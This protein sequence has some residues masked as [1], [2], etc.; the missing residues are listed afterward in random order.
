MRHYTAVPEKYA[1]LDFVDVDLMT[2]NSVG[3]K[4]TKSVKVLLNSLSSDSGKIDPDLEKALYHESMKKNK[5]FRESQNPSDDKYLSA[6]R[7]RHSFAITCHK[8]QGGEW[9]N[10][11]IHPWMAYNDMRWLYTAVTRAKKTVYSY[12]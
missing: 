2:T 9:N 7:L 8:A 1:G 10:V 4:S 5:I 12:N 6:L 11:L 3:Y